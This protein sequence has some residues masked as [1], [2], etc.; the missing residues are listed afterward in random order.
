MNLSD[1]DLFIKYTDNTNGKLILSNYLKN[2]LGKYNFTSLLDVGAGEGEFA[3][4]LSS[5][6]QSVVA[7]EPNL[8]FAQ[9]IKGKNV[10]NLTVVE[11]TIQNYAADSRFDVI[12]LSYFL[13]LFQEQDI[14]MI[15]RKIAGLRS[16]KGMILGISYLPG[17]DWDNYAHRV[18][19]DLNT[20][21]KG[22]IDRIFAK[23][24]KLNYY[25]SIKGIIDTEIYGTTLSDLYYNLSFFFKRNLKGYYSNKEKYMELLEKYSRKNAAGYSINVK[26]VVYEIGL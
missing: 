8:E 13:D 19:R 10:K 20:G 17:C 25:C 22:G 6:F 24:E 9:K 21:R 2:E 7:I 11:D 3:V 1:Q 16:T 26:E 4:C 15:M 23:L 18:I 5:V 14:E 12:L